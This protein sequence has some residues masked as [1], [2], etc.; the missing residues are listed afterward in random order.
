MRILFVVIAL[1]LGACVSPSAPSP[2]PS[3]AEDPA[4]THICT[5]YPNGLTECHQTEDKS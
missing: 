3:S 2:A 1:T 5:P 4:I